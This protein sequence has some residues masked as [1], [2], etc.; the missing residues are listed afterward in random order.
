MDPQQQF[1]L[2]WNSFGNNLV[3]TFETL[4]KSESLTDV[5]LFCEGVTF[6][7][8][9]IIL[10]AC[11]KH[12][13]DLFEAA[14]FCPNILVILDGTSSVNMSAL[15]EFMYKGEVH[16]S[17]ESLSGFL[18]AAES[19]Q[20]KGL[21]IE[22]ERLVGPNPTRVTDLRAGNKTNSGKPLD[23]GTDLSEGMHPPSSTQFNNSILSPYLPHYRNSQLFDSQRL[24]ASVPGAGGQAPPTSSSPYD[25]PPPRKRHHRSPSDSNQRASVLRVGSL[26]ERESPYPPPLHSP[27]EYYSRGGDTDRSNDHLDRSNDSSTLP[28][29]TQSDSVAVESTASNTSQTSRSSPDWRNKTPQESSPSCIL[30]CT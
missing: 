8:H 16:V 11:S 19:L 6:K 5:T 18:K 12:F 24:P 30:T 25:H 21:S 17:Q 2:K 20:I 15:L 13:Q 1:C 26:P 3:T 28:P 7:A 10:A 9:K 14:P 22:Q 4:F 27:H 29:F 23:N